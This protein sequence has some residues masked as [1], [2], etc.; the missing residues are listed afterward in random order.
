[1]SGPDS[2]APA[3]SVVPPEAAPDRYLRWMAYWREVEQAMAA[4]PSLERHASKA[5]ATFLRS[6][7]RRVHLDGPG[8]QITRQAIEAKRAGTPFF[9]PVVTGPRRLLSEAA[10]YV[11][12]R[13]RWLEGTTAME[14]VG[15]EPL[16]PE[17][18]ELRRAVVAAIR[19]AAREA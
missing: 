13:G 3:V 16:E 19:T 15:V 1:M 6:E 12:R 9:S 11:W 14:A 5:S 10:A 8:D 7:G 17:L 4:R 18:V 2:D